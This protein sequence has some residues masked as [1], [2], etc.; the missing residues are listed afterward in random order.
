LTKGLTY[1]DAGVDIDAG[2]ELVK[3]IGPAC[4]ATH[5]PELLG[6]IGGFAA[7][8]EL[9]GRYRQPVLV[10]GTDGVGTKLKLAI[11]HDH[12]DSVGQDLVAMC[13]NDV[14]VTGAEPFLFLDYY[15]SGKLDV[16]IAERVVKGIAYGCELAGCALVGGE[17]AEMPG[18]YSA[19]DYDLAGFCV[20]VVEKEEIVT[21]AELAIGDSLI[22]LSSSGPH[23]NG[24]SLIRRILSDSGVELKPT[25]LAQLLA[26]TR[27]YANAIAQLHGSMAIGGMAH[28]TGGGFPGNIPRVLP[29]GVRAHIDTGSWPR[30]GIFGFLQRHGEISE[31]EMLRVF[32][33]G[34]GLIVI[35]AQEDADDVMQRFQ[36]LGERAYR[37]GEIEVKAAPDDP[38]LVL[39]K[40]RSADV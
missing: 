29:K 15:A 4:K 22:G 23:A 35:I 16:D 30:P 33:C 5:R 21:G 26:P 32:N 11:D 28:I 17:T 9:P 37:I 18:F 8:A 24:Y 40:A 6:A 31:D 3:R 38:A 7:L 27:I 19:G 1:R 25:L 13:V 34:I 36:A 14:L 10:T 20:G 2:S 12:H 39:G